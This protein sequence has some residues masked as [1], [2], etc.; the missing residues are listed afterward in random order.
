MKY[1]RRKY[2]SLKVDSWFADL[3]FTDLVLLH[4][5]KFLGGVNDE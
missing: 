4:I 1:F 2:C 3:D 5:Y